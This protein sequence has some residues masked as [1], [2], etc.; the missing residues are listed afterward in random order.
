LHPGYL[1]SPRLEHVPEA[2][3]SN[4]GQGNGPYWVKAGMWTGFWNGMV[5]LM[6]DTPPKKTRMR[7]RAFSVGTCGHL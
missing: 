1:L 6:P 7:C 2:H 5:P 3:W 4:P